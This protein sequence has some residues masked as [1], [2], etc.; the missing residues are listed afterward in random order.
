MIM[1]KTGFTCQLR[2][3][4]KN[5]IR[6]TRKAGLNFHELP[7]SE[8]IFCLYRKIWF[9]ILL[10]ILSIGNGYQDIQTFTQMQTTLAY[11]SKP[12]KINLF[13]QI[14]ICSLFLYLRRFP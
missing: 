14:I 5:T 11:S 13:A 2:W 10:L 9:F 1:V 7:Y 8:I 6:R 4:K 12:I 3:I